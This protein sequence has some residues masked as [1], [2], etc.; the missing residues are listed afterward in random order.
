VN[1]G[2]V[3]QPRDWNPLASYAVLDVERR[4]VEFRRVAYPVRELQARLTAMGWDPGVIA[5]LSR[6]RTTS[7]A[8]APAV[9]Q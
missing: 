3:G 7:A 9:A 4:Q 1:P 8:S 5:T 6:S 2:S